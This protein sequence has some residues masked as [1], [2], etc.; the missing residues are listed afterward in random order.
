MNSLLD[1]T[2]STIHITPESHCSYVSFETNISLNKLSKNNKS[3]STLINQVF[4][5]FKPNL[6][7]SLPFLSSSSPFFIIPFLFIFLVFH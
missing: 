5:T 4:D 1:E 7:S 2:F 6:L 3:Y